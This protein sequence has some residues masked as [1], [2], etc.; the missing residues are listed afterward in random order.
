MAREVLPNRA[1]CS[2]GK[3]ESPDVDKD[4]SKASRR[5]L[6]TKPEPIP[7]VGRQ[8][9]PPLAINSSPVSQR[10]SSEARK[11]TMEAMSSG[12]AIRPSGVAAIAAL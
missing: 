12:W 9:L 7:G 1:T 11:V 5:P 6:S 8:R 4:P 10:A 3:S 2:G